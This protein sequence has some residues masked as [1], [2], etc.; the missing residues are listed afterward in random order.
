M[1]DDALRALVATTCVFVIVA[2]GLFIT[3][4][5]V[6]LYN[7]QQ[8]AQSDTLNRNLAEHDRLLK[9]LQRLQGR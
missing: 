5:A 3:T 6:R 8:Q 9:Q 4:S 2:S 7:E 1:S